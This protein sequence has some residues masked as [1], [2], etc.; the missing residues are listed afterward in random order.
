MLTGAFPYSFTK[1]RDPID[2]ILN[3]GVVLIRKRDKS[4]PTPLT[5]VLDKALEKKSKERF[6]TASEFLQALK[7]ALR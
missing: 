5:S 7:P 4:L 3:D 1:E 2:V 6:Q